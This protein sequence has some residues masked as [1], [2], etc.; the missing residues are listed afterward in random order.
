M[1]ISIEF[2]YNIFNYFQCRRS[3]KVILMNK[4]K[5]LTILAAVALLIILGACGVFGYSF[6][7]RVYTNAMREIESI[8]TTLSTV[9]QQI[10]SLEQ[11]TSSLAHVYD[12]DYSWM[13]EVPPLIAH[14]GGGIEDATYTNSR[15]AFEANYEIG[16]RIFEI[17]FDLTDDSALIASHGET[18]WRKITEN[19]S[20]IYSEKN[21]LETPIYG[22]YQPMTYQDVVDL[23][24]R[25]PDAYLVADTK[26]YDRSTVM[27]QFS[28][29][30]KYAEDIDPDILDR[31]IPQIYNEEMLDWVMAVYPFRSVIFTL[32]K[33]KWT[34]ESVLEFCRSSGVRFITMP[35]KS[36][37]PEIADL[38]D[39]LDISIAVHTTNSEEDVNAFFENGV[40]MI[41]TDFLMPDM[42]PT[43]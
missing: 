29:L 24:A 32:Y 42:F 3:E 28:Q 17:D 18:K 6:A 10:A 13:E 40:D 12:F 34:P 30:V 11:A 9:Q 5:R 4:K 26:Y 25:Y 36:F 16:H 41:Y 23:M 21:F 27:L 33:A 2:S 39:Q 43:L 35:C 38:F 7:K 14:A 20:L 31:I 37:R 15:E 1:D 19:E 8:Q 22:K